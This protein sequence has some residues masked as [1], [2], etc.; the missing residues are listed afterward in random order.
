MSLYTYRS[1]AS[2]LHIFQSPPGVV[3]RCLQVHFEGE[4]WENVSEDAIDLVRRLLDRDYSTRISAAE[5]LQHPWILSQC[6]QDSCLFEDE[7]IDM[8]PVLSAHH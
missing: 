3:L 7:A 4:K 2:P 6:G 1:H 5:A 8:M